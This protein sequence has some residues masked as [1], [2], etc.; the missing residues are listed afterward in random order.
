MYEYQV[1]EKIHPVELVKHTG[2]K[3]AMKCIDPQRGVDVVVG[4]G[5]KTKFNQLSNPYHA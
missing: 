1:L 4:H 5:K 3:G 2:R